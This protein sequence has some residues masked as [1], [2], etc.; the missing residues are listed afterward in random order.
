ML[1]RSFEPTRSG[2]ERLAAFTDYTFHRYGVTF[3]SDNRKLFNYSVSLYNGGFYNGNRLFFRSGLNYRFQ[4]YGNFSFEFEYN[5]LDF[6]EPYTSA[7]L[8]LIGPRVEISFT[9]ELFLNTFIQYNSQIQN[10]NINTRFQ[11][12]FRP[13]SDLF[14]VYTDNY[15][16]DN[17]RVKN[18]AL[19]LKLSYWLAV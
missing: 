11:W 15:F 8:F 6:P 17:F 5:K 9:D 12:R 10:L 3:R 14:I 1:Q 7:E 2:G 4:P 16:P 13:V 19:I 18:R